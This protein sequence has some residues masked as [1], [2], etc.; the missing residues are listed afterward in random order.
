MHPM[1]AGLISWGRSHDRR[2]APDRP[3]PTRPGGMRPALTRS[4]CAVIT[5]GAGTGF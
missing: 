4:R 1:N 2:F 3:G 5:C